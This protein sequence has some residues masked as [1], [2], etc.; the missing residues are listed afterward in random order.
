MAPITWNDVLAH[1]PEL[2]SVSNAARTDLLD[3]VNRDIDPELFD[4]ETGPKT[5]LARIYL[6]AH[7]GA[8]VAA[9]G[10]STSVG[11]I[12]AETAGGLSRSYGQPASLSVASLGSTSYGQAYLQILR[13]SAARVPFVP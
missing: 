2:T 13:S 7:L 6:A 1:A 9:S 8:G 12:T 10:G 5:K 4:G 3:Y 11:S